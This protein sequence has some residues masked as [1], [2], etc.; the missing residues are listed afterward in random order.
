[1]DYFQNQDVAR[2]R[3][4]LLVFLF[5]T[6]VI[7]IILAVY[8]A[9]GLVLELAAPVEPGETVRGLSRLWNPELFGM[10]A[11]G[12]SALVAGGSLFKIAALS[13]GGHT[14]A[15]L[16]G[17]RLLHPD[18]ASPDERRL[19]N[20]V[21]E[22]A[23]AAGLPV[24]PVYLLE[25]ESGIN[26]FAAGHTTND[27]VVAVTSGT[28]KLL[29]RDELQGVIAHEFS[30]ILNG[31]M[32]L[33]IRLM[34][35]IFGILVIGLTGW[36]I[37]RSST[38]G[39]YVRVGAR[40]DDR[41]G[42][43]PI[44]LIGLALYVIGYVGVFF[45]N[46]IKAAVSRQRE[47]LADASA[48]QFTRNPEGIAGALKK[49]GAL[50][51]GSQVND[52]HAEEASHMFFGEAVSGLN[53]L[54]GLLSTHPPLVERIRRIDPSFTGDFSQVR[55]DR[56]EAAT[57]DRV[58]SIPGARSGVMGLTALGAVARV[59]TID[60]AH[61]DYAGDLKES[62]PTRLAQAVRDPLGAQATI[63]ALLLDPGDSVRETQLGWLDAYALPAAARETR[64]LMADARLLASEARLPLVEMAAPALCQMTPA[65]F[66]E[67]LR[68]VEAL[69][70]A[71]NKLTLFEYALQRLLI[72]HVVAHFVGARPS[73]VK[74]TTIP[75]LVMPAGVVLS[76]L[77]Y[78]GGTNPEGA[79]RVYAA[80]V[81][82][83]GW[84]GVR[85]G[86]LPS[87]SVGIAE[88]DAALEVL[89]VAAPRLKKQIV[90][91]C[92]ACICFDNTV[93]IDEAELLRA[94]CDCLGC[95]MPPFIASGFIARGDALSTSSAR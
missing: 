57:P 58:R 54:F 20:V 31:D 19:L 7:F 59:G 74:F 16:L 68:C 87:G 6:A 91:A 80:G 94:V 55:M 82:A 34:G 47:F 66:H 29:T 38:G 12:T 45:G 76:A 27:A 32:R 48:V 75:P 8:V 30:H 37:F 81:Q 15:E 49:I 1:M 36:I 93:T 9:I 73:I 72:R 42:F 86:L 46:L 50:A 25:N 53:E 62:I 4:G 89:A 44:P 88:I 23:I 35:A 85:P 13:G 71:D 11:L 63:F 43:N 84:P 24:P 39:G 69:V 2:K 18:K 95:P 5:V 28:L 77:A 41:K 17:G 3:T 67:F 10:V 52:S 65:Q 51:E 56:I 60:Q 79:A 61:I 40:D 83:L 21:E 78:A 26:A 64:M 70:Q 92:A 90:L 33:N 22:M 14:V